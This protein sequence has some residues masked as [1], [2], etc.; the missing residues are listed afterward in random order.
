MGVIGLWA[1]FGSVAHAF[2]GFYVAGAEQPLYNDATMVVLLREGTHTVLSMRNDYR[3]PPENFAMVVPVPEVLSE[4]DVRTLDSDVFDRVDR[5]AS[6]RLVEYWE[7]DPCQEG[8]IGDLVGGSI[9]FGGLGLRGTGRG[10]GGTGVTIEA[11]FAVGEYDIVI[12]SARDSSGLDRWLRAN[13]YRIPEGAEAALRPYVEAGT[14]FFVAKVDVSKVTFEDGRAVLSP[15][16]IHYESDEF[17]LPVRLGML[18]SSGTQ[19]L[20]VHILAD[21]QRYEVANYPNV[22]IPTNLDLEDEVRDRFGEVYAAV[23]DETLRRNPGSVVTEYSWQASSCDPCP[24]GTG[25]LSQTDLVTLGSGVGAAAAAAPPAASTNWVSRVRPAAPRVQGGLSQEVVR[26]VTRR[27]MNELRF[28]HQQAYQG[29]PTTAAGVSLEVS[30]IVDPQGR[31]QAAVPDER[32]PAPPAFRSCVA[33]AFRRWTFPAPTN[34]GVVQIRQRLAFQPQAGGGG[35]GT[36]GGFGGRGFGLGTPKILTR[37]HYRYEE[38]GL[39]EDLVFR[40][41]APIVGGREQPGE[42]GELSQVASTETST[43]NFQARYAI[44]HEWTGPIECDEPNRGRWG[45]NPHP[46]ESEAQPGEDET[47]RRLRVLRAIGAP[48]PGPVMAENIALAPRGNIQLSAVLAKPV[49]ALQIT[50]AAILGAADGQDVEAPEE[51]A[52]PAAN[53]ASGAQTSTEASAQSGCGCR[54]SG[55]PGAGLLLLGWMVWVLRRRVR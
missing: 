18:N 47:A 32:G 40:E 33:Q 25:G 7:Q 4:D 15:L 54:T 52:A 20:L 2:C 8:G 46:P 35:F 11:E 5:L 26:R 55:G 24:G 48:S 6:P 3:G 28:C 39:G 21:N 53:L 29:Q 19:D 50:S 23:F 10:G 37:L 44:R 17:S 45:P 43:N 16:R 38:G 27:H 41:A 51:G 13:D 36:L 42:D 22:T 9:G 49:P 30:Y 12:L 1:C 14:K 31:V 34:A